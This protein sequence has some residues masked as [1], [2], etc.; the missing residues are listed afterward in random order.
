MQ[1]W[2]TLFVEPEKKEEVKRVLAFVEGAAVACRKNLIQIN[3]AH[4]G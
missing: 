1:M 3:M 4:T 2:K